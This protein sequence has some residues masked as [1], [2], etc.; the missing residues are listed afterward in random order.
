[1]AGNLGI[2]QERGLEALGRFYSIYRAVVID[3]KD[4]DSLN[5]LKLVIPEVTQDE[6]SDWAFPRNQCGNIKSGFKYLTP[7]IGSVVLV[8]FKNGDPLYPIWSYCGWALGE[9]PDD[10]KDTES[11]GI[12]T[13][14]GHKVVLNDTNGTFNLSMYDSNRNDIF[15]INIV[16]GNLTIKGKYIELLKG[17]YGIPLSDKLVEKLNNIENDLNT[18][19]QTFTESVA[20]VKPADGG[21]SIMSYIVSKYS[22]S[23]IK[24]TSISDIENQ[25][26]KQ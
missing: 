22:T 1:M 5:R 6:V 12:V 4:P 26:V 8:E 16:D 18:L 19:K 9:I 15:S 24:K 14:S 7:K 2:I 17:D 3:N 10:L 20:N 11:V 23:I 25:N 21:A 13:P